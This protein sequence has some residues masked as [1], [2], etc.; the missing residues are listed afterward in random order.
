M[1]RPGPLAILI[2]LVAAIA[3]PATATPVEPAVEPAVV[4]TTSAD[5]KPDDGAVTVAAVQFEVSEARLRSLAD[6]RAQIDGLVRRATRRYEADVVVFPEYLNVFLLATRY[7]EAVGRADDLYA[8]LS[9]IAASTA[10]AD[11]VD[12]PAAPATP[13]RVLLEQADWIAEQTLA[14]W[15][16]IADRHDVVVVAGT[17]F[18]PA[19]D[20]RFATATRSD[21]ELRNRLLVFDPDGELVYTQDKVYLTPVEA[22][23]LGLEPGRLADAAPVVVDGVEIG[24]TICRDTF[25]DSWAARLGG[26]DLW[27]DLRANG[28]PYSEEV[29]R[30]FLGTLPERVATTDASAGLNASLT[31]EFLGHVWA[32]PSYAVAA[33]GARIAASD[34]PVGTQIT[35]LRLTRRGRNWIP[36]PVSLGDAGGPTGTR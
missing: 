23:V 32:G 7:P 6:V 36:V 27:I 15:S 28:E 13:R 9:G 24:F 14:M 12:A 5:G 10:R 30:R 8:A 19:G 31:G 34:S 17:L 2:A 26:V 25:F 11:A 35:A 20:G 29:Y 1:R 3:P 21:T 18:A 4:V 16:A 22:D 33:D